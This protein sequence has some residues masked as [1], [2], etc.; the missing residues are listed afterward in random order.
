MTVSAYCNLHG[1]ELSFP[2]EYVS[3]RVC[4]TGYPPVGGGCWLGYEGNGTDGIMGL[5]G[6]G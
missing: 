5:H 6:G 2:T 3:P 4:L 1:T